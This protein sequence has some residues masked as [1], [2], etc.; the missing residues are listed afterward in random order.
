MHVSTQVCT[1]GTVTLTDGS[2]FVVHEEP[3]SCCLHHAWGDAELDGLVE[4]GV[5]A[6]VLHQGVV[7]LHVGLA[8]A[9]HDH[10]FLRHIQWVA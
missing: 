3:D 7:D 8:N 6:V 2:G 4:V 5:G 10:T 9:R 1:T